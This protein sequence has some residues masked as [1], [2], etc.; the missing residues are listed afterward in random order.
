MKEAE[1]ERFREAIDQPDTPLV[2]PAVPQPI[3]TEPPQSYQPQIP[4]TPPETRAEREVRVLQQRNVPK[5][6]YEEFGFEKVLG[7]P[8]SLWGRIDPSERR[9]KTPSETAGALLGGAVFPLEVLVAPLDVFAETVVELVQGQ[10]PTI[11]S[12][13]LQIHKGFGAALE[14]FTDRPM[15]QQILLG[16]I[17]DPFL[18]RAASRGLLKVAAGQMTNSQL[19]DRL[20]PTIAHASPRESEDEFIDAALDII[21]KDVGALNSNIRTRLS[22]I[23]DEMKGQL[24]RALTEDE[25]KDAGARVTEQ[26]A[27]E[28]AEESEALAPGI[29]AREGEVEDIGEI[30]RGDIDQAGRS[31]D[32]VARAQEELDIAIQELISIEDSPGLGRAPAFGSPERLDW[33]DA[34]RGQPDQT[35]A[36]M[37]AEQKSKIQRLQ[38]ALDIQ[39][40]DVSTS[41]QRG[42]L[43][44]DPGQQGQMELGGRGQPLEPLIDE[45]AVRDQ[46]RLAEEARL[47]QQPMIEQTGP[48]TKESVAGPDDLFDIRDVRQ[49]RQ[50]KE[51]W[52]IFFKGTVNDVGPLSTSS[53]SPQ[54]RA[55]TGVTKS[56][57]SGEYESLDQA[58]RAANRLA[59]RPENNP[60][61]PQY[62]ERVFNRDELIEEFDDRALTGRKRAVYTSETALEAAPEAAPGAARQV[63]IDRTSEVNDVY[64]QTDVAVWLKEAP[65]DDSLHS[66]IEGTELENLSFEYIWRNSDIDIWA[67]EARNHDDYWYALQDNLNM[68]TRNTDGKIRVFRGHH[69]D[70]DIYGPPDIQHTPTTLSPTTA[71]NFRRALVVGVPLR[72]TPPISD[73]RISSWE[74][75]IEDIAAHGHS[76][77]S[78]LIVR[79]SNLRK[80]EGTTETVEDFSDRY[81]RSEAA[82]GAA[83][84][85]TAARQVVEE[86]SDVIPGAGREAAMA[87]A[88]ELPTRASTE[89]MDELVEA[90]GDIGGGRGR[91][92][93]DDIPP[94]GGRRPPGSRPP[95]AGEPLLPGESAMGEFSGTFDEIVK[96]AT[97]PDIFR[98]IAHWPIFKTFYRSFN[99][100]AVADNPSTQAKIGRA[101]LYEE[102]KHLSPA[103]ISRLHQIGTQEQIFGKLD[104]EGFILSGPL[105]GKSVNDIRTYPQ[106]YAS[107]TTPEQKEW[108]KVANDLEESK[109]AFLKNNDIDINELTFEEGGQYA[110]RRVYGKI[111]D[112][113]LVAASIVGAGPRRP[114]SKIAS[115]K[116]RDF[117]TADEAIK[118]GYRYIPDDEALLLNIQGA[119]RRVADKRMAE[120]F[121][122]HVD[123]RS[124]ASPEDLKAATLVAQQNLQSA[125]KAIDALNR[126][127]RGESLPT[128]T[129]K[130]IERIFPLFE[131]KLREPTKMHVQDV[132]GAAIKLQEPERV[133]EVPPIGYLRKLQKQIVE[134]EEAMLEV[135]LDPRSLIRLNIEHAELRRKL[136]FT[137]MMIKRGEPLTVPHNPV[138]EIL[139]ARNNAL[140]MLKEVRDAIRGVPTKVPGKKRPQYRGGLIEVV[141]KEYYDLQDKKVKAQK[142]FQTTHFV[143]AEIPN[144]PAFAGVKLTGPGAKELAEDMR[145][146]FDPSF[147]KALD[148]F[149]QI[150]SV[151]RYF[152]LAGDIGALGIQ[153][154]YLAGANPRVYV[155]AIKGMMQAIFDTRFQDKYLARAENQAMV[156]KYP[157]LILARRGGTEFTQ[158]FNRG[159]LFQSKYGKIPGKVLEPFQRGFE[160][161]LDVAGIEMAKSYDHLG[162]TAQR[163]NDVSSFINEFRGLASS[164]SLGVSSTQRQ[165]ETAVLLAPRYNRAIASLMSDTIHG[166]LRG[167]MTRAALARSITAIG[168]TSIIVS[169]AMGESWE[170]AL[171][172]LNPGKPEFLTWK[173]AGQNI[174]PGTKVR[175]IINLAA[176]T[177]RDPGSLTDIGAYT[178]MGN[179]PLRFL[180]GNL[181]PV[182][183]LGLD[184]LTGRDYVGDPTRDGFISITDTISSRFMPIWMDTMIMEGGSFQN[185]ALRGATEF[186]GGRAYPTNIIWQLHNEWRD[187]IDSYRDIATTREERMQR[188][189]PRDLGRDEYRKKNPAI[190]A[191][192][193]LTGRV[194]TLKT[195]LAKYRA[196]RFLEDN[197]VFAH[198][199]DEELIENYKNVLGARYIEKLM[200]KHGKD[201][202]DT[203]RYVPSAP[204]DTQQTPIPGPSYSDQE[205]SDFID[206]FPLPSVR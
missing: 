53:D 67:S 162:T 177:S 66:Y 27:R 169:M 154:F 206:R 102:A 48:I 72:E 138:K 189:Q 173:I 205:Y 182:P 23:V 36:K 97:R 185:R 17:T 165:L 55:W 81:I 83:P 144:V 202:S 179:P 118:A 16:I 204:M 163:R 84:T 141:R 33:E 197:D 104:D 57:L 175:S 37:I 131:G 192:L 156:R 43:P 183:G 77:E 49:G 75:P 155:K 149:N 188:G 88:R 157:S 143:E 135:G 70:A 74:V 58:K 168:I 99:P 127:I 194:T 60:S 19:R 31:T 73:W 184:L 128:G 158:A 146:S 92:I 29:M 172:H 113:E 34:R 203:Q 90:G 24:G 95:G 137:K 176:R 150:N 62:G 105:S 65:L 28:A 63:D 42:L 199:V 50:T 122:K 106:R 11:A 9:A 64:S 123:W 129:V 2:P 187:D 180:R 22:D 18:I 94:D 3:E 190:D 201:D 79:K 26:L 171:G 103:A 91:D 167:E 32:P 52:R 161:A 85:P 193:F 12:H 107:N 115:E 25:Y 147:N 140:D 108:I 35:K 61:L 100:S 166:G 126:A 56:D 125:N 101:V 21:M 136:G 76:A 45:Q 47:G 87:S 98:T 174:G 164:A 160:G 5:D 1:A 51:R 196:K 198:T 191:K 86:A 54:A 124:S 178:W 159:G 59:A 153:L 148:A 109:L 8:G 41:V 116:A 200:D 7:D 30:F 142:S 38:D 139:D 10:R 112:G 78:E 170:E 121:L 20:R 117:D 195:G 133:F 4:Y 6:K 152:M 15:L 110:G 114:G 186:A 40:G 111:V 134:I 68:M 120:W 130:A 145:K 80:I 151:S 69:K 89:E 132:L 82:P 119:Y 44:D 39:K 181:A 71:I 96:I 93:G 46:G 13:G 14:K